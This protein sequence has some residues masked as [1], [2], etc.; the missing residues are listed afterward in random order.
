MGE[1]ESH[2]VKHETV[3][4][5]VVVDREES[6][7]GKYLCAYIIAEGELHLPALKAHLAKELPNYM[8]PS[9][10]IPINQIPLTPNGKIDRK[11]LPEPDAGLV[12]GVSYVAPATEIE[13]KL[14]RIWEEVLGIE[15]IGINHNFFDIGGNSIN[16]IKVISMISKQMG[17]QVSISELFLRPTIAEIA[18]NMFME[19]PLNGLECI[20]SLNKPTEGKKNVFIIHT[21]EGIIYQYKEIAKSLEGEYNIYGIQAKGVIKPAK[22]PETLEEMITEYIVEIKAIQ[23]KGPY[24]IA[25]YCYGNWIAYKMVEML[26][27]QGVPIDR[28]IQIDEN[29]WLEDDKKAY[30]EKMTKISKPFRFA[31]K[32]FR[33][34]ITQRNK[35]PMDYWPDLEEYK[36]SK[37]Q[38]EG[39]I[40]NERTV[41]REC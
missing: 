41:Q 39:E 37:P 40:R 2:L 35:N 17:V 13:E 20:V 29:A 36:N 31:K 4:E 19:N 8:I 21:W 7:G 24:I 9:F 23:P 10:F 25:G 6:S 16:I 5:C 3:K 11:A 34:L 32:W 12:S 28:M 14:V 33:K 18:H 1:I 22:L 15:G 26:E 27:D 38:I 30:L